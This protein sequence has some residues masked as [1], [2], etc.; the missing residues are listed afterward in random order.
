MPRWSRSA[1]PGPDTAPDDEGSAALE[2]IIAGVI[3]LVPIVYLIVALGAIQAQALGADAGARHLARSIATAP[4][5]AAADQRA[6]LLLASVIEEYGM[7][8]A[9]VEVAASCLP[10]GTECPAAGATLTVRLTSSVPLPLVPALFGLDDLARV[11]VEAVAVQKVSRY[12]G[13]E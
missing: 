11:P 9:A 8:P 12:W 10:V 13:A 3:L 6:D 7:D 5:A 1:E 2:F 4:D